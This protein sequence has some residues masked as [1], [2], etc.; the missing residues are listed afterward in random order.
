MLDRDWEK[1]RLETV[2]SLL[3]EGNAVRSPHE[4]SEL[5]VQMHV[6]PHLER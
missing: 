1:A 2:R 4:R 5:E 6:V 3:L